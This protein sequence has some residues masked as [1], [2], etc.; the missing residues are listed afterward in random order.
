MIVGN[1]GGG[2][3]KKWKEKLERKAEKGEVKK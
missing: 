3:G 1:R 2:I